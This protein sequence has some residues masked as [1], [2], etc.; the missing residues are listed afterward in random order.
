M[1]VRVVVVTHVLLRSLCSSRLTTVG[2]L[3][4]TRIARHSLTNETVFVGVT[5]RCTS[6]AALATRALGAHFKAITVAVVYS[7]ARALVVALRLEPL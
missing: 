2:A 1:Q 5:T 6:V 4:Y 7:C 3:S